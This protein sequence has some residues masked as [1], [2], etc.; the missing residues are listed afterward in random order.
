MEGKH[1]IKSSGSKSLKSFMSLNRKSKKKTIGKPKERSTSSRF[2]FRRGLFGKNP[3]SPGVPKRQTNTKNTSLQVVYSKEPSKKIKKQ[4]QKSFMLLTNGSESSFK[5]TGDLTKDEKLNLCSLILE[6]DE[7]EIIEPTSSS[8]PPK[9]NSFD[10]QESYQRTR[11][12]S[13]ENVIEYGEYV[14]KANLLRRFNKSPSKSD[15][16]SDLFETKLPKK[17]KKRVNLK[18]FEI[19]SDREESDLDVSL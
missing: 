16:N 1:S 10:F 17:P 2:S 4:N 14:E 8:L 11:I 7:V 13:S 9:Q 6:E 3:V 12:Q 5:N 18:I 15:K 19:S